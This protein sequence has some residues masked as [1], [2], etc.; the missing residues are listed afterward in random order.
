MTSGQAIEAAL[1]QTCAALL[2]M[3]SESAETALAVQFIKRYRQLDD[4]ARRRFFLHLA[5][6]QGPDPDLVGAAI[7]AYRDDPS[8][9]NS[10]ALA[11]A[12]EPARQ[13]IIRAVNVAPGATRA[14][15][16][17]RADLLAAIAAAG[18]GDEREALEA[19]DAD[20]LHILRS[21]FNRGFLE[22]RRL[23]W[24]TPTA[25]LERLISYEAVHEVSGW[26][27]L[28]RRLAADRRCFG[29]FHPALPDE[30]IIF[31]A[32]ALTRGRAASIQ[33]VLDDDV[34]E[35]L[36]GV[37][38][39]MFYS[40]SNCQAGL[41]GVS[42]GHFLL[43]RVTEALRAELPQLTTFATL[44]P[45]PGLREWIS[46][47]RPGLASHLDPVEA[48]LR[49]LA[50]E[51]RDDLATAAVDY[52]VVAKRG[53]YPRDSVARFHL[54]NGAR[55]EALNHWGDSSTKGWLE[56]AGMLVNYL[57]DPD[58]LAAQHEAY[59][60]DGTVAISPSIAAVADREGRPTA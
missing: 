46:E 5:T 57:Y 34:D 29:F 9:G 39:A 4:A 6:D 16:G 1:R 11:A 56:S 27:D 8:P 60:D 32:V 25:I 47:A 26:D 2:A 43:Q 45:I 17:L 3:R 18:P 38:H 55:I 40:I 13:R 23:D 22:L 50:D 31:V 10:V 44:S 21:W 28:R 58:S 20:L 30:P 51:L 33:A 41:R 14:L 48:P 54:R 36:E 37:D 7:A 35:T 59:V 12:A 19:V 53:A 15:V 24:S 52:L 42:F 49:S